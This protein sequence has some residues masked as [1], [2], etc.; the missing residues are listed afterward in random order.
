MQPW[1]RNSSSLAIPGRSVVKLGYTV[2][3]W[4]KILSLWLTALADTFDLVSPLV[5]LRQKQVTQT[6]QAFIASANG[7]EVLLI[8][9]AFKS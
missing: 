7:E 3:S 8:I 5:G 9:A 2:E 6:N 4:K 1:T